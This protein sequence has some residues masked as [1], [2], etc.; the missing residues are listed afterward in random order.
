MAAEDWTY[1]DHYICICG[2]DLSTLELPGLMTTYVA[3]DTTMVVHQYWWHLGCYAEALMTP[4]AK[5]AAVLIEPSAVENLKSYFG[6]K[7]SIYEMEPK[8]PRRDRG[9]SR[10]GSA[11]TSQCWG[12]GLSIPVRKGRFVVHNA[13]FHNGLSS[14]PGS[15]TSVTRQREL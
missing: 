11:M 14:C 12:C 3:E 9:T 2:E 4:V 7:P 1:V 8:M 10:K 6:V 5:P 13:M 15:N